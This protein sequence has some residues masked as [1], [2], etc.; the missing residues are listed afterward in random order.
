MIE[1]KSLKEFRDNNHTQG[2]MYNC[3]DQLDYFFYLLGCI[4]SDVV[5]G[6]KIEMLNDNAF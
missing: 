2:N 6:G 3:K 5:V 4:T 1:T